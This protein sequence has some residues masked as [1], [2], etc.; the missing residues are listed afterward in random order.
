MGLGWVR[1]GTLIAAAHSLRRRPRS[2]PGAPQTASAC[3]TFLEAGA[4]EGQ[5]L[6]LQAEPLDDDEAP[7]AAAGG[8][9]R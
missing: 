3:G 4:N 6:G 9:R 2:L 8:G 7:A 5:G 1:V